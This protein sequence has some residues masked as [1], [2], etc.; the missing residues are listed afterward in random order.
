MVGLKSNI[1]FQD[2]NGF[3]RDMTEQKVQLIHLNQAHHL[4]IQTYTMVDY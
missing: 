1:P 2:K 4:R 3:L